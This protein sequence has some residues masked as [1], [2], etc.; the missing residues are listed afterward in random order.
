MRCQQ[1]VSHCLPQSKDVSGL[2]KVVLF[3][4]VRCAQTVRPSFLRFETSKSCEP[5]HNWIFGVKPSFVFGLT[6]HIIESRNSVQKRCMIRR[7]PDKLSGL[8]LS[9]HTACRFRHTKILIFAGCLRYLRPGVQ[10]SKYRYTDTNAQIQ[11]QT[12]IQVHE[13]FVDFSGMAE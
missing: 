13:F 3:D 4:G 6:V 12:A 7:G 11:I 2:P 10:T 5:F 1:R 9:L 8:P